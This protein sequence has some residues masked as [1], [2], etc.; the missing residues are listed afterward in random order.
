VR[1]KLVAHILHITKVLYR[2]NL[3]NILLYSDTQQDVLYEIYYVSLYLHS[4]TQGSTRNVEPFEVYSG[5][6][7]YAYIEMLHISRP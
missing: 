5:S 4:R 2:D 3:Y 7:S 1:P 6:V